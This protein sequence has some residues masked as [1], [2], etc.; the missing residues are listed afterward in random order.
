MAACTGMVI[1]GLGYK[2]TTKLCQAVKTA[3]LRVAQAL[4][5]FELMCLTTLF[6]LT[7]LYSTEKGSTMLQ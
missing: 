1:C 7:S 3:L 2:C 4:S 6:Q 5:V